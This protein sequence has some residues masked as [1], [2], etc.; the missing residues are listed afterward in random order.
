MSALNWGMIFYWMRLFTETS[1]YVLMFK[2]TF[3]DIIPFLVMYLIAMTLLAN[4]FL[5]LD[6]SAHVIA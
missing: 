3:Y 1:F 2:E 4:A 6:L 5:I